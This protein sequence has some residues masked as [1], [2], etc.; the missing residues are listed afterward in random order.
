MRSFS[1]SRLLV[2]ATVALGSSP[3]ASAELPKDVV[4]VVACDSYRDLKKQLTWLGREVGQP[5]LAGM[6]EGLLGAVTGGRGLAG[7]DVRQP[8]G[9]VITASERVHSRQGSRCAPDLVAGTDGPRRTR[10]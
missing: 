2:L 8:F 9:V 6:A 10:R 3:F 4:A 1:L 7:L 5:A